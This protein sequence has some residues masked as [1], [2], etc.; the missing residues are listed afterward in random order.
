LKTNQEQHPQKFNNTEGK[1]E[2]KKKNCSVSRESQV[3]RIFLHDGI[4]LEN[5]IEKIIT[6]RNCTETSVTPSPAT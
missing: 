4:F 1:K 5:T 3:P 6:P 2:K